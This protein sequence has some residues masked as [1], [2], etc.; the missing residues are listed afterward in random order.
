MPATAAVGSLSSSSDSDLLGRQLEHE[1]GAGLA[2]GAVL[3]PHPAAVHAHVLVD[4]RQA[5]PGAVAA[6]S[7]PGDRA[8][9]EALEDRLRS[10][11]GTPGPWSST[12]IHT[13]AER[14]ALALRLGDGDLRRRRRRARGRCR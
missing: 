7:A 9:G 10:S 4:Q 6:R 3:D 1:A 8:A 2:V 13:W 12:A 14:L 5:E 11:A